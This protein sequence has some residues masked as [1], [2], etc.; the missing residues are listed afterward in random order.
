MVTL[1]TLVLI[2]KA[3]SNNCS[4]HFRSSYRQGE[5]QWML[6]KYGE[7][8]GLVQIYVDAFVYS[9]VQRGNSILEIN[10]GHLSARVEKQTIEGNVSLIVKEIKGAN[11]PIHRFDQ[12]M[13]DL[14]Y[15]LLQ[16]ALAYKQSNPDVKK[17]TI[18]IPRT[19]SEEVTLYLR[20]HGYLYAGPNYLYLPLTGRDFLL[21]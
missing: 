19:H 4:E 3:F 15:V 6:Y 20:I 13:I 17:V 21:E 7:P 14:N 10:L 5:L 16:G 2:P 18:S 12:M 11:Q 8:S 9:L 1:F